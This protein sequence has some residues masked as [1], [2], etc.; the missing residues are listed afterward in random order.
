MGPSDNL[1]EPFAARESPGDSLIEVRDQPD[2]TT[3]LIPA[4]PLTL[5]LRILLALN[6]AS[7]VFIVV[8]GVLYLFFHISIFTGLPDPGSEFSRRAPRMRWFVEFFAG[9]ILAIGILVG[10]HSLVWIPQIAAESLVLDR[11]G[12]HWRRDGWWR[13]ER[14]DAAWNQLSE[15][16]VVGN[17]PEIAPNRLQIRLF[18]GTTQS[19]AEN[20]SNAERNWLEFVVDRASPRFRGI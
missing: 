14:I 19:I 7:V 11:D 20:T 17:L 10:V 13:H 8:V 6:A 3:I 5:P 18:D 2:R 1:P 15:V 12:L 9:W 4:R 16:A